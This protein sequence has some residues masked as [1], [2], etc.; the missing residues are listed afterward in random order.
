[1]HFFSIGPPCP[2]APTSIA[3]TK[4]KPYWKREWDTFVKRI[5]RSDKNRKKLVEE[6]KDSYKD[7]QNYYTTDAFYEDAKNKAGQMAANLEMTLRKAYEII[8]GKF[9][10]DKMSEKLDEIITPYLDKVPTQVGLNLPKLKKVSDS[11][12]PKIKL[13]K[14]KKITEDS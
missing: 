9:T 10:L 4:I 13:P 6:W 12:P 7:V 11:N 3:S 8:A 1:M 2:V 5:A 14:L